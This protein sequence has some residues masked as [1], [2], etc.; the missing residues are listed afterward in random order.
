MS[1]SEDCD[2]PPKSMYL[3]MGFKEYQAEL[4]IEGF[5]APDDYPTHAEWL[6]MSPRERLKWQ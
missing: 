3:G 2:H 6:Q 1:C 4:I 5:H